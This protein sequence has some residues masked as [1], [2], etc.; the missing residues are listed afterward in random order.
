MKKLTLG[1]CFLH[2]SGVKDLP[3][4]GKVHYNMA[5]LLRDEGDVKTAEVHYRLA[6]K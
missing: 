1:V 4:N 5:N 3:E 2:R 6:I